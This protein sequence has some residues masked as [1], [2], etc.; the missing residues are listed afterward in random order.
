MIRLAAVVLAAAG[1]A[2][3]GGRDDVVGRWER[4]GQ[5]AEWLRFEKDGTFTGRSYQEPAAISGRYQQRGDTL[6]ATSTFGR[7][8]TLVLNDS[9]LVMHDGT[10]YRRAATRR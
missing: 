5:P 7:G 4:V 9:L 10:T 1:L 6:T 2:C 8:G 3:G